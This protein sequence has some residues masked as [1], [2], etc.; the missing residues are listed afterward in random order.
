MD[1][2]IVSTN[3]SESIGFETPGAWVRITERCRANSS[4]SDWMRDGRKGGGGK[5]ERLWH[6]RLGQRGGGD[7]AIFSAQ[8]DE[9]NIRARSTA[10]VTISATGDEMAMAEGA[11]DS[12]DVEQHEGGRLEVKSGGHCGRLP[13]YLLSECSFLLFAIRE[14]RQSFSLTSLRSMSIHAG[15]V[16]GMVIT[17]AMSSRRRIKDKRKIIRSPCIAETKPPLENPLERKSMHSILQS[18][19][20]PTGF[21]E[22]LIETSMA[23][24]AGGRV[25]VS[26]CFQKVIDPSPRSRR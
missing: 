17:V 2:G 6:E 3:A 14:L 16:G 8:A 10:G 13:R 21:N 22:C 26:S 19:N 9:V 18:D 15:G 7:R 5:N 1:S 12:L 24:Y 25:S 23:S 4:S 20:E 11:E